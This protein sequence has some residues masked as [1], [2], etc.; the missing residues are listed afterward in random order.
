MMEAALVVGSWITGPVGMVWATLFVL[1]AIVHVAHMAVMSGRHR[2]WHGAHV[3][4]AAGMVIM[5]WPGGMRL[6]PA[7]VA[8]AVYSL[9]AGTLV[10][11]LVAAKLRRA[12]LG[13]LW[14]ANVVDLAAM[15]YMFAMMTTRLAWL[16]ALGVVW[17][18][19]QM[20]GWASGR[21]GRVL[22][23]GGLGERLPP[24]HAFADTPCGGTAHRDL[25]NGCPGDRPTGYLAGAVGDLRPT[26]DG[27]GRL[28]GTATARMGQVAP[29]VRGHVAH[30][31]VDGGSRDW[32][33]RIALAVMSAGMIYMLLAMQ[34]GVP[35]THAMPDMPGM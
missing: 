29:A 17:F 3:L 33:V 9:A 2:L 21:L 10:V 35:T 23:R 31:V 26:E 4:M 18:S 15:A 20:L 30:R 14:L 25:A 6:V 8:M 32:S 5:F 24:T 1:V 7:R 13:P 16:S 28:E 11:V 34:F 19:V 12:R 22:E 27:P